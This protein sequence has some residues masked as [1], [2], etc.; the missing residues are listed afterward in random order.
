MPKE[1]EKMKKILIAG[2]KSYIGVSFENYLK[3]WRD[4]YYVDTVDMI[5]GTWREKDFSFYDTVF[6]VAGIAHQ[7]ETHKNAA[8]YYKVNR[9]LVQETALKAK[10]EGVHQFIFLSSMNIYGIDVGVITPKTVPNP[11]SNYGKSKYEAENAIVSLNESDFAVCILRPPMVY[12]KGCKGNFQ[13]LMKLVSRLPILPKV[14]NM[15]SMVYIDNLC[16]F[17]KYCLDN[18]LSGVY[19]PQNSEYMTTMEITKAMARY[20]NKK[21]YFSSLFGFLVIILRPFVRVLQKAYGTLIYENTEE[22]DFSYCVTNNEDSL[23]NSM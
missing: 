2:A 4:K 22:F 21:R 23:N 19:F 6:H 12:G 5:D 13:M 17:V 18:I 15:R 10:S 16:S 14:K 1:T 8:L 11:K 7:K 9:D 3:Q 20:Q